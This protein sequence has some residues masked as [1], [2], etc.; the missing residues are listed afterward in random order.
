MGVET[1]IIVGGLSL[2]KGIGDYNQAKSSARA[3]AREGQIA[4]ENRKKEIQNLVAKQ[5]I[6]YLQSGVELEGTAQAVMQDTYKTGIADVK[7]IASATNKSI[8]NQLTAAR[9]QLLGS[10]ASSAVSAYSLY[11]LSTM[12]AENMA[13]LTEGYNPATTPPPVKPVYKGVA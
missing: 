7:D 11:S 10:I 4:I 2:A 13:G 6:G 5:K 9:A 12:G 1:A 8:K 3:T